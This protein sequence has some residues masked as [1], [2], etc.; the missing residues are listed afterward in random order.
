MNFT[1]YTFGGGEIISG[2]FNAVAAAVGDGSFQS[3][4]KLAFC[5]SFIYV[6]VIVFA[7][8]DVK[9]F[10]KWMVTYYFL[11]SLLVVPKVTVIVDD[12]INHDA[13]TAVDNVPLGLAYTAALTSQVGYYLTSIFD[14]LFS[15]PDD[16]KYS[17]TGYVMASKLAASAQ[18]LQITNPDFEKNITSFMKQCL[19]Y[20]VLQNRYSMTDL[21]QSSN[22]LDF[23]S[24]NTSRARA[25]V[26]D[27]SIVTCQSGLN[28]LK[29]DL[30]NE[31]SQSALLLG[32]HL[33]SYQN[34]AAARQAFLSKL[35][36]AMSYL[37]GISESASDL[38]TQSL[39]SNAIQ[40]A[41]VS[42]SA[43]VNAEAA[44]SAYANVRADMLAKSKFALGG[45]FA[46]TWLPMMGNVITGLYYA[47]FL[48]VAALM[49]TPIG[50]RCFQYYAAGILWVQLWPPLFAVFNAMMSYTAKFKTMAAVA[51]ATGFAINLNTSAGI[52]EIN[53][54]MAIFA[55]YGALMIPII[56]Y[57]IVH[58]GKISL[59]ALANQ[60]SSV[61]AQAAAR[62]AEEVTTGNLSFGNMQ[63]SNQS[64]FNTSRNQFNTNLLQ[65]SGMLSYQTASGALIHHT[66]DGSNVI[67]S[68]HAISNMGTSINYADSMRQAA[69]QQADKAMTLGMNQS[70]QYS[71]SIANTVRALYELGNSLSHNQSSDTSYTDS[72][73]SNEQRALE[74]FSQ[75]LTE[76]AKTHHMSVEDAAKF[77]ANAYVKGEL[78]ATYKP[79][80]L[81][82][83]RLRGTG[84]LGAS[85]S[86]DGSASASKK[87][88]FNDSQRL[89]NQ[90]SL[91]SMVDIAKRYAEDNH[92]RTQADTAERLSN[93]IGN[94]YEKALSLRSDTVMNFNKA[95][96]YR[97]TASYAT[98]H[99]ASINTN[100]GQ[101]FFDWLQQQ[102]D[103]QGQPFGA[104]QAEHI[105]NSQPAL[106][107]EYANLFIQSEVNHLSHGFSE[108][109]ESGLGFQSRFEKENNLFDSGSIDAAKKSVT[110]SL[111]NSANKAGLSEDALNTGL[112]SSVVDKLTQSNQTVT[113][114]SVNNTALVDE[115]KNKA[116]SKHHYLSREAYNLAK[117]NIESIPNLHD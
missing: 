98:E 101:V 60:F 110:N 73:S 114:Q 55:G 99:A 21:F 44:V 33:F 22:L 81:L 47:L 76:F 15:L 53:N 49:A 1:V 78:S 7:K 93:N 57:G 108:K 41:L 30:N 28:D 46:L 40:S 2:I 31:V 109:K 59:A 20:D 92:Y 77:T 17:T 52:A 18:S 24:E 26:Y 116:E 10:L 64:A 25:F 71:E 91:K 94:S 43:E 9:H 106:A 3:L 111:K 105:V 4:I 16:V 103:G 115:V 89:V 8:G 117:E 63:M 23:L 34:Q 27:K 6:W 14:A 54:N 58:G 85:A 32:K 112:A 95:E 79:F 83:G 113:Q 39:L 97:D 70:K 75:S 11:M 12:K 82:N 66:A 50:Y 87:L 37:T 72:Q 90:D 96:S 42:N 86:F 100:V 67:D 36:L 56:A 5:M 38:M 62:V 68:R 107:R 80:G 48:I 45:S 19:F 51:T 104:M 88:D 74:H 65:Q 35:P 13:M 102:K 84:T 29:K 61:G 69:M